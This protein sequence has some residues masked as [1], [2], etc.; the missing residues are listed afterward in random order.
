VTGAAIFLYGT[1]LDRSVLARRSGDA[2]LGRRRLTPA[3][4][5]GHRRVALRATPYPTLV[6]D[7][8]GTVQ[9]V[10]LR[11]SP[12][13]LR[14]LAAYEGLPYRLAPLRVTTAWGPRR[15]R[16]WITPPWRADAVRDWP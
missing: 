16:A 8:H 5:D 6:A 3:T 2:R 14:R 10:L 4:L 15:V 12:D 13:A 9:G 7:A 1:L 11:P